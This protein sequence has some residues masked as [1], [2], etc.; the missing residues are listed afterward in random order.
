MTTGSLSW[1]TLSDEQKSKGMYI[2]ADRAQEVPLFRKR[3]LGETLL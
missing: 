2:C 1:S 3:P